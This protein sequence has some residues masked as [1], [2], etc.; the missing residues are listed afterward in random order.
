MKAASM[1]TIAALLAALVVT[2]TGPTT[3]ATTPVGRY[4]VIGTPGTSFSRDFPSEPTGGWSSASVDVVVTRA[5]LSDPNAFYY[6]AEQWTMDTPGSGD[7]SAFAY[8]GIQTRAQRP[9]KSLGPLALVTLWTAEPLQLIP[10]TGTDRKAADCHLDLNGAE[11][12]IATCRIAYD[13]RQGHVYRYGFARTAAHQW[14]ATITDESTPG[15]PVTTL[16]AFIV[17]AS[18]L[19]IRSWDSGFMEQFVAP[20]ETSR[21]VH[22]VCPSHRTTVLFLNARLD[23]TVA[24]IAEQP[25]VYA[26]TSFPNTLTCQNATAKLVTD[27]LQLDT[28]IPNP[29]PVRYPHATRAGTTVTVTWTPPRDPATVTL[30]EL[31]ASAL[32]TATTNA[33]KAISVPMPTAYTVTVSP[34]GRRISVPASKHAA[35]FT[36]LPRGHT[37]TFS[38]KATN[39]GAASSSRSISLAIP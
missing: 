8:M 19:G 38:I 28:N 35:S 34:G 5:P 4:A 22:P 1:A 37:Y 39:G 26:L 10:G 36:G 7:G 23:D 24:P 33:L 13:W 20:P 6:Y 16:G 9:D 29:A 15:T 25:S 31:G 21:A 30:D 3:F 2:V 11:G 18:W 14:T 12:S 17:P 32:S 27:G